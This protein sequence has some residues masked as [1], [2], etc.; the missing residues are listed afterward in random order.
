[1]EFE[2]VIE[3][4]KSIREFKKTPVPGQAI[5]QIVKLAKRAPS[6]GAVRGYKVVITDQQLVS[7]KAPVYF[8][9]FAIPEKYGKRYGQR[10]RSLYAIQDATLVAGYIQLAAISVG[11][12]TVW[13]GA[14]NEGK[15]RT[16][17][18]LPIDYRPIAVLPTGYRLNG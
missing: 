5:E 11:L 1:M 10:G 17:L 9:V 18:D 13:V 7:Y 14:F 16:A 8:V 4:R 3:R 2:Q 15:V 6:A 12:D